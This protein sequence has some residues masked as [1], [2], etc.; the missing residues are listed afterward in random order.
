MALSVGHIAAIAG[1]HEVHAHR[2]CKGAV[3]QQPVA[4]V[5]RSQI[6]LFCIFYRWLLSDCTP[7]VYC[8]DVQASVLFVVYVGAIFHCDVRCFVKF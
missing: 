4:P 1:R 8:E 7:V 3:S 5:P 6:C 2:A